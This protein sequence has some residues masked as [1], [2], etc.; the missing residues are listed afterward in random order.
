MKVKCICKSVKYCTFILT[1]TVAILLLS[2]R[3]WAQEQADFEG[4][5]RSGAVP[6]TVIFTDKSVGAT[7]WSWSFPGGSP[8]SAFGQGD[9]S[10]T[11]DAPGT[12]TVSLQIVTQS[13][14][15]LTETKEDYITVYEQD[16]GD[17]PDPTFPTLVGNQ[18]ARHNM[19]SKLCLGALVDGDR[20]GQP[21]A[22]ATGDD[23]DGSDDDD[24]V[25]FTTLIEM[26]NSVTV[27]VAA[28]GQGL[29]NAWID[30]NGDGD[31]D[32]TGEEI[33]TNQSLT[34]GVN[35]L[36]FNVPVGTFHG[37]TF[38]RFRFSTDQNLTVSGPATDGEV[39]DYQVI[40]GAYDFGDAPPPYPTMLKDNGARHRIVQ[41][42]YL[43]QG[44]DAEPDGKPDGKA[45]GDDGDGYDDEDGVVFPKPLVPGD[46]AIVQVTASVEGMLKAWIDFNRD[47]DWE[48]EGEEVLESQLGAGANELQFPVPGDAETGETYAR[49]RFSDAIIEF[50]TGPAD[51][52]EVE[53]IIVGI[54]PLMYY[55]YGDAPEGALAYKAQWIEASS[56]DAIGDFPTCRYYDYETWPPLPLAGFIQHGN[57]GSRYFGDAVDYEFEGNADNCPAEIFDRDE[58]VYDGDA[59]LTDGMVFQIKVREA[60]P[61]LVDFYYIDYASGFNAYPM[62]VCEVGEWGRHLDI[63]YNVDAESGAYV[64]VLVDWNYN[65]RWCEGGMIYHCTI[66]EGPGIHEHILRDFYVPR[67]SGRLSALDPPDFR[68]TAAPGYVW[69]RFTISE[70]PVDQENWKGNG[71]FA[72]GETEDYLLYVADPESYDNHRDWGDAPDGGLA[73]PSLGVTGNFPTCGSLHWGS[74]NHGN[75]TG[76]FDMFFG[77]ALGQPSVEPSGNR[78]YCFGSIW[79]LDDDNGLDY[80]IPYTY[81][82]MSDADSDSAE[83]HPAS[84]PCW[85]INESIGAM[86]MMA[87]WGPFN[88][89]MMWANLTLDQ[90]GYINVLMDWNQD[91]EWGGTYDCGDSWGEA[92]E[93]VLKNYRVPSAH[94]GSGLGAH[95]G[96]SPP[97][98]RIGPNS[99]YVWARF[100][101]TP[102]PV[103]L[104]WDGSGSYD[105]GETEDYLLYVS[106]WTDMFF[107]DYGDVRSSD[108]YGTFHRHI[109]AIHWISEGF[110]LGDTVDADND[111]QSDEG[112]AGDDN[113][114]IDD[115]DGVE[116]TTNFVPGEQATVEVSVTADG[117][118]NAWIDFNQDGSWADEEDQVSTDGQMA[119]GINVLTFVVPDI[120]APGTTFARFRFSDVGGLSYNGPRYFP[121]PLGQTEKPPIGEVEDYVIVVEGGEIEY[122]FGDVPDPKYP[123]LKWSLGARHR[124][125]PTLY[126]GNQIDA[127]SDGQPDPDAL[128]DDK[129]GSDDE[130]GVL[131]TT[132]WVPGDSAGFTV[133][134]SDSGYLNVWVDFNGDGDWKDTNEQ[135]ITEDWMAPGP[136]AFLVIV[137]SDAYFDTTFARFRFSTAT[138]VSHSGYAP[139]GEVEDYKV[140]GTRTDVKTEPVRKI[141]PSRFDLSQNYPNPFN[142]N[143]EI[144]FQLP[145]TEHVKLKIFN[146]MGQELRTLVD[147]QRPAGIHLV[148]WDA[149]DD[150]GM[151]MPA[152]LYLY[153]I[154][155]G[156][157]IDTK[158]LLLVK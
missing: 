122:D 140:I 96:E 67:G 103:E 48:D 59:G 19:I 74:V 55:E 101:I 24:G 127:D 76:R 80:V 84:T 143:T 97:D 115:E 42:V 92:D 53:D 113:D 73:Y 26:G 44:V 81:T 10:V 88:L 130:D 32:D 78:G 82:D 17:A 49:F 145:R 110:C 137:P 155:A 8:V 9:H 89:D 135:V 85:R 61:P 147:E 144:R 23:I 72:D 138:G 156:S 119:E 64:N 14:N 104:P 107:L 46:T 57:L 3:I 2:S 131:F 152:G 20:N 157:F 105:D 56:D 41:G 116:F 139:D 58:L 1:L 60:E 102:V 43:G 34:G 93:H 132:S 109:G 117:I 70:R 27:D 149:K 62:Y 151:D 37:T 71:T 33:F 36:S 87:A 134:A 108:D 86:C 98:F 38:A 158:K 111:G 12:Y 15:T 45:S 90:W 30:F 91:G 22:N 54:R 94:W 79:N 123:T 125:V 35:S 4:A 133:T 75:E 121:G 16:W 124:I 153:R 114:G 50:P 126:L 136:N 25:T 142:P 77:G 47:G 129:D 148:R 51:A 141:V 29:L 146:M 66:S 95:R 21:N 52:G 69:A 7:N 100:T 154:V 118:L 40:I 68:I 120:A 63:R 13:Q 65:G 106:D 31:W 128:G 39:E 5:P 112:A 6:L 83:F 11:Y 18:G 150:R 28:S 99:G